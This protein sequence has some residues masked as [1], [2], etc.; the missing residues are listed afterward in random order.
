MRP[1]WRLLRQA[2][3]GVISPQVETSTP[4]SSQ[5]RDRALS[6]R[7]GQNDRHHPHAEVERAFHLRPAST[8][9]RV[10]L[11]RP[12]TGAGVHVVRSIAAAR[13]VGSTRPR[14][15][16]SPPLPVTCAKACTSTTAARAKQS[17]A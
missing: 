4:R 10:R 3:R 14:F 11:I 8:W 1:P 16:V 6:H 15:A 9:P 13:P 17:W 7:C 5:V 12:K 2:R